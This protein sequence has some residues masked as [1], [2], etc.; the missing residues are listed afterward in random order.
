[1]AAAPE[2]LHQP[3]VGGAAATASSV[4]SSPPAV[5]V[6][7]TA[8]VHPSSGPAMPE[9]TS[10]PLTF[11]DVSW[12]PAPPVQRVFFYRLAPDADADAVLANLRA[13]L[14]H[15][16]RA[17]FPLAGRLR[18]TPGTTNRY[19]LHYSPDDAVAF[20]VAECDDDFD[21]LAA[22]EPREVAKLAPLAPPL[23]DGGAVLALQATLLP[24]R[25]GHG[26]ALGVTVHHAAC[27]GAASTHFLRSWAAA[28]CRTAPPPPPPVIN[29][30]L[31]SDPRGLYDIFCP[32]TGKT[33][34][35]M[36]F[37]AIPDDQLLATFTLSRAHLQRVKDAV[38][39]AAATQGGAPPPRCTSLVASLGFVWSCYQRA[40]PRGGCGEPDRSCL[41]FS[42]DH[43]SRLKPPLPQEYFGNCVASAFAIASSSELAEAGAGGLL[44]ACTAIAAGIEDAVS[45]VATETMGERQ[46][47]FNEVA[48]MVGVLPVAGSPRFRVYDLDM[49][50]GR[51]AKV[52]VVSAAKTGAVAVAESRAGDGGMEV[53]VSLTPDGMDAFRNAYK[54]ELD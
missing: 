18:L 27:D 21:S 2:Q 37:V 48:A 36:G 22:D 6:L 20:T 40:K 26:L 39:A 13:A 5:R 30:N 8:L 23:P 34:E 51:P 15:A 42:V 31:V 7:D 49:G 54:G 35:D 19:E 16:V 11:F 46:G 4:F 47:R 25:E 43:R 41:L 29:R 53:G 28:A 50:F 38:A 45:G 10:L 1:M 3:G 33:A 17:F 12:V 9:E 52:D 44:T 24:A 14:S 32:A